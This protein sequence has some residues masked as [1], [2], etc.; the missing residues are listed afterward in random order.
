MKTFVR[1]LIGF[2]T[3]ITIIYLLIL[4]TL[5]FFLLNPRFYQNSFSKPG[6]YK[7]LEKGLKAYARNSLR[8]ELAQ[9][10]KSYNNLTVGQRKEIDTQIEKL[11]TPISEENIR[12]FSDKNIQN[13]LIYANGKTPE[14]TIYLPIMKW[15]L[16]KESIERLPD[17]LT[18]E[19]INVTQVLE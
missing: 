16:P 3:V 6:V 19:N 1:T 15:G 17:Y 10:N 7:N 18:T 11:L 5:V 14:L 2:F 8:M 13:I 12:D 9:Q 4:T